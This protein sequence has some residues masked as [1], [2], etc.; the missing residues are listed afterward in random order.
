[1]AL[2]TEIYA[3]RIVGTLSCFDR[4]VMTGTVVDSAH[5]EAMARTPRIRG[6][7]FFDDAR[8]AEPLRDEVRANAEKV[9]AELGLTIESLQRKNFR[10]EERVKAILK[11]RGDQ[12]GRVHLF[13]AIESCAS[14]RPW[15][16]KKAGHTS[17]SSPSWFGAS[18]PSA[19]FAI[20]GERL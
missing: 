19:A 15:H 8:F 18:S 6:V 12:P 4:V 5:P 2:L 14:Y 7:R 16:D 11:N 3:D 20:A 9:A 10:K 13:F 1:M 17:T